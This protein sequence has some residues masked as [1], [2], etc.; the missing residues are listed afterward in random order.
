MKIAVNRVG[1]SSAKLAKNPQ[2]RAV[3]LEQLAALTSL[4]IESKSVVEMRSLLRSASI[5]NLTVN[6]EVVDISNARKVD[7]SNAI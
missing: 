3:A 7:L 5:T 4:E 1:T 2:A 6:G